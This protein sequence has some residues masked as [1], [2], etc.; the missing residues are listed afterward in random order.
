MFELRHEFW[1]LDEIYRLLSRHGAAL[2]IANSTRHPRRE[3]TTTDF[4]Y[5][6]FHGPTRL[7]TSNYI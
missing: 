5:S 7:F 2:C 4:Q 6:R 3:V 1:F